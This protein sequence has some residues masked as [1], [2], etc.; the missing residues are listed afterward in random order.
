M[1]FAANEPNPAGAAR[2]VRNTLADLLARHPQIVLSKPKET[3]D[4]G[5]PSRNTMVMQRSG[6][7]CQCSPLLL[8]AHARCLG[9]G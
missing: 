7:S 5:I 9:T 6:F 3:D 8:V 2:A 4:F 1:S